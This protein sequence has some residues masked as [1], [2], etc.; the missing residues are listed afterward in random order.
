MPAKIQSIAEL[1]RELRA[2]QKRLA[3]L[4]SRRAK[5]ARALAAVDRE[6]AALAGSRRGR[7]RKVRR[8]KVRRKVKKVTRA[9]RRP[10][11]RPLLKYL[12]SALARAANG[13]RVKDLMSA[14]RKA[15]YRSTSKD[16]YG[17]VAKTL[18][19]NK[20]FQRVKRGV[21]KLAK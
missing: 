8:R 12:E 9:R 20:Q 18:L 5:A 10:R 7:P 19:E 1:R 15:G 16:F 4:R 11:G 13:M 3:A 2:K 21:Y 17:I 6:I 14:V